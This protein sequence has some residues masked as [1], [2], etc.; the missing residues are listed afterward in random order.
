MRSRRRAPLIIERRRGC[1]HLRSRLTDRSCGV[2]ARRRKASGKTGY[3]PLLALGHRHEIQPHADT[4]PLSSPTDCS[5]TGERYDATRFTTCRA[6]AAIAGP[7]RPRR[8]PTG[9]TRDTLD[10]RQT[11][12]G[13]R[14]CF[15]CGGPEHRLARRDRDAAGADPAVGRRQ[16]PGQGRRTLADG[17]VQGARAGHGGGHGART[18]GDA[19]RHAD[20]RQCRGGARGL[21]VAVRDRDDHLRAA[22]N[23]RSQYPRN[24]RAGR[25]RLSRQRPDRRMRRAGRTRGGRRP[26]VRFLD[27]QGTL[28]DRR[29]ED[30]GARTGRATRLEA[31]RRDLLPDRGRDRADRDV[32]GLRRT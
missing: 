18:G 6:R 1:G 3:G 17:I 23:P 31:A 25:P 16:C 10:K 22:G 24:R 11:T 32:E 20:Q 13:W 14:E 2:N 29:Q 7:L 30:D 4:A 27:A 21:C 5:L 19:N 15:R 28:S 26:V 8:G 12:V 9:L